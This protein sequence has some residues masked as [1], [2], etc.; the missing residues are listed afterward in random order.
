LPGTTG[1]TFTGGQTFGFEAPGDGIERYNL[2]GA[3][4]EFTPGTEPV[5]EFSLVTGATSTA[6]PGA[7]LENIRRRR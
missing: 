5:N 3:A 1:G 4:V 2:A 6:R 7:P